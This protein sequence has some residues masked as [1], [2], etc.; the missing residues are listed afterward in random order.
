[1]GEIPADK[2]PQTPMQVKIGVWS[3]NDDS[4]SGEIEWAGGV[5][6]WSSGPFKA[7]FQN[8]EVEDYM[9]FCNQTDGYVEYQYDERTVGWQNVRIAGCKSR[10]GPEL[11]M[12]SPVQSGD[13]A[14][15]E[16][17]GG[18]GP[19][20]SAPGADE[21][22]GVCPSMGLSSPLAAIVVFGWFLIL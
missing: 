10:P 9:G 11:P 17:E 14:A 8:I 22:G 7:Y 3:V 18:D 12:P 1:V 4:D 16:T 5:P 19:G 20:E 13:A 2:W 15:T 21:E 6:D